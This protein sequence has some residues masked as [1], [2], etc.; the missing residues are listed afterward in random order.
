MST[1]AVTPDEVL[2]ALERLLDSEV[3]LAAPQS[4]NFLAF[5]VTETLA[6]RG[7]RLSERTVGRGALD[8]PEDFDGRFDASVRVRATR[9]RKALETYYETSP[10][11]VQIVLPVGTY[12]PIFVR[13]RFATSPHFETG[14]VVT[15]S[16]STLHGFGEAL[17]EEMTRQLGAFPGLRV[18]GSV[19][20]DDPL[21][22]AEALSV[23]F[24]LRI[25][26]LSEA[27]AVELSVLD[28]TAHATVWTDRENPAGDPETLDASRWAQT[29]AGRIGD[30]TGVVLSRFTESHHYGE[31]GWRAM[32]A[33]YSMFI[34]GDRQAVIPAVESL[35]EALAS[36]PQSPT[37]VGALAHSLSIRAGYE[38][39]LDADADLA[40]A[41]RLANEA[42]A[43]DPEMATAHL[44]L[45]TV[46]LVDG[47]PEAAREHARDA[48]ALAP[49]HPSILGTAGTLMAHA[50]DW[51]RG[52]SAIRRALD[53]NPNLPGFSRVLLVLD[54]VFSGDDALALA[55]AARIETPTEIWGPYF[56]ALALMG[57]GYRQR[58]L[59][60]MDA[61]LA[62]DPKAVD[63][64]KQVVQAWVQLSPEQE[65]VLTDRLRMFTD[66]PG[67][68]GSVRSDQIVQ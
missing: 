48:A 39:S 33:Y 59:T 44:A 61:A 19:A 42:L 49:T 7:G 5:V 6:G 18:I 25:V 47:H 60:E 57:L 17:A 52:V 3:F 29:I 13:A 46:A 65:C 54:H 51:D 26:E 4:R 34:S 30:F 35:T 22:S 62:L 16:T 36:G 66:D 20:S 9:V 28:T 43:K 56:R 32:Q 53:L 41:N 1:D 10:D 64:L 67:A 14:L 21:R 40:E 2:T 55:E 15:T 11:P 12:T 45:A 38:L 68:D 31:P 24:A 27:P 63:D 8:R 58:A 50:G 23:R 37:L